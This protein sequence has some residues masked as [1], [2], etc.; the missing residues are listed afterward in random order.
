MFQW[1]Y[2]KLVRGSNNSFHQGDPASDFIPD[3]GKFSLMAKYLASEGIALGQGRVK[4]GSHSKKA[5]GS[6]FLDF[7]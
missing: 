3:R 6:C 7:F 2:N 5:T 1:F 4:F